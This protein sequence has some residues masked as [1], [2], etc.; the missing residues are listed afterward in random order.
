MG[1]RQHEDAVDRHLPLKP[2]DY[3][4]LVALT[5]GE[6]H[7]YG[8]VKKIE[9]LSGGTL[10]PVPGNFYSVLQRLLG[11]GLLQEAERRPAEDLDDRRRRYY[12]ISELGRAVV[13]AETAR[14]KSLVRVAEAHDLA[15]G[16][17]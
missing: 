11:E 13:A 3:L 1:A 4:T 16:A 10:K 12:A 15:G 6:Q 5:E 8:L 9:A 14:L 17:R 7:G 2:A